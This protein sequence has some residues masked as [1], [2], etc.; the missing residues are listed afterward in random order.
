MVKRPHVIIIAGP[1]GAGKSTTAPHLLKDL[2]DVAEFVN[3]DV[4]AQ[5]LSAFATET[6]AFQA[7]RIMLNRL[8][9]LADNRRNFAFETTLS[10]RSYAAFLQHLKVKDYRIYLIFFW[11][12]SP[13]M[14][15]AR[16]AERVRNG[17]HYVPDEVV[18]RRY[19][20]GLDNF[21]NLY[22]PLADQWRFYDNADFEGAK[23]I[24]AGSSNQEHNL[25]IPKLWNH[26]TGIYCHD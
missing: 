16:V 8:H 4:I 7:G 22:K 12:P 14:S 15:I 1:N 24:A 21:F 19:K 5:G 6:V 13:E 11:L 3:A 2:F 20:R 17:G 10:T 9:Q 18:Q 26:L 23:L 25:A